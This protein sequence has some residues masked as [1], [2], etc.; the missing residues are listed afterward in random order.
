MPW[1][2]GG[3]GFLGRNYGSYGWNAWMHSGRT[4][5][6]KGQSSDGADD[7]RHWKSVRQ[8]RTPKTTPFFSDMSWVD[9]W[10]HNKSGGPVSNPPANLFAENSGSGRVCINRHNR[11][12]CHGYVDGSAGWTTLE[13]LW[14]LTWN[15]DL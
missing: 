4:A 12:V 5:F 6:I 11:G 13:D 14:K 9:T 2:A 10:F 3:W 7:K 1:V 15:R 8:C